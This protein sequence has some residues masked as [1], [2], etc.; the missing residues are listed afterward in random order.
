MATL[1]MRL[2]CK[3]ADYKSDVK[4][5]WC[6]GCG[7]YA[8]LSTV[9]SFLPELGVEPPCVL[10]ER[11]EPIP[12]RPEELQRA[13]PIAAPGRG[14]PQAARRRHGGLAAFR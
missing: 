13:R 6:P 7:D 3:P 4:P 9:Q 10:A 2:A 12:S 11:R 1:D 5:I 8:I 14:T